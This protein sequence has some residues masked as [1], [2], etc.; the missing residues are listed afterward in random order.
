MENKTFYLYRSSSSD[1]KFSIRPLEGTKVV[2]FGAK[3]YED[4]TKHKDEERK[5]LYLERHQKNE[6]WTKQG[7]LTPGFWSRWL[8]WNKPSLSESIEDVEDRFN[9]DIIFSK[10]KHS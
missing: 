1:K 8:L 2:H 5:K 10:Q 3:G 7:I 4:F 9:V 6:D